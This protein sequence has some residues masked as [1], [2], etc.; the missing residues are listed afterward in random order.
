MHQVLGERLNQNNKL[1]ILEEAC[2][3]ALAQGES[4]HMYESTVQ[5]DIQWHYYYSL[6]FRAASRIDEESTAELKPESLRNV[7]DFP[8]YNIAPHHLSNA[9]KD[10]CKIEY[11]TDVNPC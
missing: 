1:G 11:F 3:T 7:F 10:I 2:S 9:V 6:R 5:K 4:R 8:Y